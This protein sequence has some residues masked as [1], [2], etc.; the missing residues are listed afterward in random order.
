FGEFTA[1][2]RY[3]EC[4]YVK[5]KGTGVACPK[6]AGEIVERRSRRGKVFYGCSNYPDCDFTLWQKPIAEKC[7]ECG[8]PYLVEK[9]TRR[10]GRQLVCNNEGCKHVRSEELTPV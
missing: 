6:D 3:P 2:S 5:L 7:P 8:A 1:C 9:I 4:K 10:H